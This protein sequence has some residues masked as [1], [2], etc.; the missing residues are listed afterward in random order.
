MD[1]DNT[2][3]PRGYDSGRSY[4]PEQLGRWVELISNSVQRISIERVLDLGC[5]TGRYST[6]LANRL[7]A[8]V[9]GLE[10]SAKMLAEAKKKSSRYVALVRGSGEALPLASES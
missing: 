5:G 6:A 3:M 9:I 10:P 1:Y 4:S 8:Q 2:D 7:E